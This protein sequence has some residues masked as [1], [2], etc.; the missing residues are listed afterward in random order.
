MSNK[1]GEGAGHPP[2]SA[3]VA[4]QLLELLSSDDAFRSDFQSNPGAALAQLGYEPARTPT[5]SAGQPAEGELLYCMTAKTL[6]P[7]EEIA[8]ARNQLQSFL[9]SQTD[10]RVVFAFEAGRI[11]SV[12]RRK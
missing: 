4:D 3:K 11:D 7:K 1:P 8:Q 2:L 5:F 6:A 10:H 9:T 12:L